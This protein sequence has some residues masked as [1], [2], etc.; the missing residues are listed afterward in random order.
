MRPLRNISHIPWW[1]LTCAH[2]SAGRVPQWV[3]DL[4]SP[5][6]EIW[7]EAVEEGPEKGLCPDSYRKGPYRVYDATPYAIPCV[8]QAI[9][10]AVPRCQWQILTFLKACAQR[11]REPI[12]PKLV[13]GSRGMGT[14]LI[15]SGLGTTKATLTTGIPT[16][17]PTKPRLSLRRCGWLERKVELANEY[18]GHLGCCSG[19]ADC[20]PVYRRRSLAAGH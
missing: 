15:S 1:A 6:D 7:I 20:V 12:P 9:H 13:V 18:P 17:G 5:V 14:A 16:S 4:E 3:R 19:R 11:D 8:V 2:G 10:R